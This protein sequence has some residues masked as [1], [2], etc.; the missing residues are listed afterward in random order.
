MFMPYLLATIWLALLLAI[1]APATLAQN[2]DFNRAFEDY[3]FTYNL[4]RDTHTAYVTAKA[5]YLTYQ[6]LAAKT[7]ALEKTRTMLKARADVVRTYL[8]ALRQKM[9]EEAGV[10]QADRNLYQSQIDAEV[11]YL[12]DHQTK[13]EAPATLE[14]LVK[15]GREFETRYPETE[16]L[17][18]RSLAMIVFGKENR[19]KEKV[20]Q[21]IAALEDF[22]IQVRRGGSKDT[23]TVERWLLEAKNRVDLSTAK[24][25]EAV[26]IIEAIKEREQDKNRRFTQATFLLEEGNQ[27]LKEAVRFLKEIILEIKRA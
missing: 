20:N 17:L 3:L 26:K 24:Q 9:E 12:L 21:Q 25:A 5:T 18:Y 27:Y 13:L 10:S 15:V 19:L 22:A 2:L 8:T 14:D 4:Y 7:E 11:V 16:I 23:T 6:T 1:F